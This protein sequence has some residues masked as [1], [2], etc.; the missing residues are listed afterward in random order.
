MGGLHTKTFV[1]KTGGLHRFTQQGQCADPAEYTR[2]PFL[3]YAEVAATT[4]DKVPQPPP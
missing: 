4:N 1:G 3:P 2:A